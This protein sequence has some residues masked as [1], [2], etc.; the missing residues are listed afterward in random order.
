MKKKFTSRKYLNNKKT[1]RTKKKFGLFGGAELSSGGSGR[2]LKHPITDEELREYQDKYTEKMGA[3]WGL[4]EE[5]G[6]LIKE[7]ITLKSQIY[8]DTTAKLSQEETINFILQQPE[9]MS[10]V[11]RKG[12]SPK[13][14]ISYRKNRILLAVVLDI[15]NTTS[16]DL[17]D[18]QGMDLSQRLDVVIDLMSHEGDIVS[19][20]ARIMMDTI[21][22]QENLIELQKIKQVLE[23]NNSGGGGATIKKTLSIP[24][25]SISLAP[26]PK[27]ALQLPKT[28]ASLDM[29]RRPTSAASSFFTGKVDNNIRY[30]GTNYETSPGLVDGDFQNRRL[31]V[32]TFNP[33]DI[34]KIDFKYPCLASGK[35]DRTKLSVYRSSGTSYS[36]SQKNLISPFCGKALQIIQPNSPIHSGHI[37]DTAFRKILIHSA[38]I[39]FPDLFEGYYSQ[40]FL[41]SGRKSK[42]LRYDLSE[43][44]YMFQ[45]GKVHYCWFIKFLNY[46]YYS[47]GGKINLQGDFIYQEWSRRE[48]VFEF[49]GRKNINTAIAKKEMFKLGEY[50]M[51]KDYEKPLK[52]METSKVGIGNK[53]ILEEYKSIFYNRYFGNEDLFSIRNM[54]DFDYD[55]KILTDENL[56]KNISDQNVFGLDLFK[57][58]LSEIQTGTEVDENISLKI[59]A[60]LYD[61]LYYYHYEQHPIGA[62]SDMEEVLKIKGVYEPIEF[63]VDTDENLFDCLTFPEF[64]RGINNLKEAAKEIGSGRGLKYEGTIFYQIMLL[65]LVKNIKE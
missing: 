21:R 24:Q 16:A 10:K 2:E 42:T 65:P 61:C 7:I 38:S 26:D 6:K 28:G 37:K 41:P 60:Y 1:I 43:W 58:G 11:K 14:K 34:F 49:L 40:I 35:E 57:V 19:K 39:L 9:I 50:I 44:L 20:Y 27:S 47:A 17:P 18:Y 62:I 36:A 33:R 59:M 48:T 22:I 12:I 53:K 13:Y 54:G 31:Q 29:R 23:E 25:I 4:L 15:I 32:Q 30:L 55:S 64:E 51:I 5:E 46:L 52:I 63:D 56:N 45:Q 8:T 3:I